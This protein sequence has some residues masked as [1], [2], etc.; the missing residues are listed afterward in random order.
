MK[1]ILISSIFDEFR[2]AVLKD[3][4]L[5]EFY[6]ESPDIARFTGNIYKG[7]VTGVSNELEANFVDIGKG[8]PGF[9]PF[10]DIPS[11]EDF[12]I[13]VPGKEKKLRMGDEILVQ[14]SKEPIGRKGVR[15]TSYIS[16][17][18]R[19]LVLMPGIAHIGVSRKITAIAER[20]RIRKIAMNIKPDGFGIIV[21]TV[22]ESK[23][24]KALKKDL[25]VLMRLWGRIKKL[26]K[27]AVAPSLIHQEV[28]M[29][30]TYLRDFF[31][32][33]IDSLL[34]DSRAIYRSACRYASRKDRTLR[35]RIKLY[36]GAQPLFEKYNLENNIDEIF[37]EKK[38]LP[39]G[40]YIVIEETEAL[41]SI[42]V[43]SGS[44]NHENAAFT[45][46]IEAAREISRQL[47]L[48]DIGGVIVIDFINMKQ[49]EKCR[50]VVR[51][52]RKSLK[53]D[54]SPTRVLRMSEF[55]LVELTRK[56]TRPSLAAKLYD[57]CPLCKGRGKVP[58][59]PTLVMRLE[60]LLL[61]SNFKDVII[62]APSNLVDYI[63]KK[64]DFKKICRKYRIK[65][66]IEKI[67]NGSLKITDKETGKS[68]VYE[69]YE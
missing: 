39:S 24:E 37:R 48:R 30:E 4:K 36:T 12:E 45:T 54:R 9:L 47:T 6:I 1:E 18:G 59:L 15:L 52:L 17:P 35:S 67:D 31:T 38:R 50:K 7:K 68:K 25:K 57:P 42:D 3:G 66:D 46:N 34:I 62:R 64:M 60:N 63:D 5:A 14:I 28:D 29:V 8:K 13:K 69:I 10:R 20:E 49:R 16:L 51:E 33:K 44:C 58:S 21:R 2:F 43:N 41:V 53:E 11:E 65:V 32:P 19:Y 55:G 56:R 27:R 40:G 23:D 26:A 61:R 22:A